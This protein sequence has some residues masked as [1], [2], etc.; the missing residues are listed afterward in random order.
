MYR[1]DDIILLKKLL[2]TVKNL[3]QMVTKHFE[4]HA[5]TKKNFSYQELFYIF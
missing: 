1:H 4:I 2:K 5:M 3:H